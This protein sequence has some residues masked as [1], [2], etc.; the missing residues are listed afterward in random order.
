MEYYPVAVLRGLDKVAAKAERFLAPVGVPMHFGTLDVT[1]RACAKTPPEE[2][3]EAAA[4]LEINESR[5]GTQ[6]VV[7]FR[8]WMYASSPSLSGLEHPVY[9]LW[10]LDCQ[11]AK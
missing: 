6:P 1:V 4:Y 5:Q 11:S 8:G 2:K 9:D 10:L 3:P 7:L